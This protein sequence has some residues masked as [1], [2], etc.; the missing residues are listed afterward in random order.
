M[1]QVVF[2]PFFLECGKPEVERS[3]CRLNESIPYA[4]LSFFLTLFHFCLF[5]HHDEKP[6]FLY[7][8]WGNSKISLRSRPA[9]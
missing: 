9:D 8:D 4:T 1:K 7:L 3:K 6:I 2:S 5:R